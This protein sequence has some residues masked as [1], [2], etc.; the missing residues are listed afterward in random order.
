L[1]IS[2]ACS[3]SSLELTLLTPKLDPELVGLTI[4]GNLK[5]SISNLLIVDFGTLK[6]SFLKKL[7]QLYL[8]KVNKDAFSSQQLYGI[9][10]DS[11]YLDS[12]PFSAGS[13]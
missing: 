9:F 12:S 2:I 1:A 6:F 5:F 7:L 8:L 10:T 11:K 4:Q 3:N 13:P